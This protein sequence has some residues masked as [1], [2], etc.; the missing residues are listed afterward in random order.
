VSSRSA[1]LVAQ[2]AIR[3]FTFTVQ[4]LVNGIDVVVNVIVNDVAVVL[5]TCIWVLMEQPPLF[6]SH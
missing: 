5:A 4:T 6:C 3:F 2:T 1:V